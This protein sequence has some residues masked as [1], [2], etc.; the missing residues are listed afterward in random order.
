MWSQVDVRDCLR[1]TTIRSSYLLRVAA[2][3]VSSSATVPVAAWLVG[4][5]SYQ[6]P[7]DPRFPYLDYLYRPFPLSAAAHAVAATIGLLVL[8]PAAVTAASKPG[9]RLALVCLIGAGALTGLLY[10]TMT[11]GVIGANIGAGLAMMFGGPLLLALLVAGA[12]LAVR[13]RPTVIR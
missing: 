3:V 9:L 7:V 2:A 10:R 8:L 13:H 5:L 11:A 6:G 4:D 1:V 12:V